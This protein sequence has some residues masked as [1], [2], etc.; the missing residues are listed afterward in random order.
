[1]ELGCAC[2]CTNTGTEGTSG[3]FIRSSTCSGLRTSYFYPAAITTFNKSVQYSRCT[4]WHFGWAGLLLVALSTGDKKQVPNSRK[5]SWKVGNFLLAHPP[6]F[7]HIHL[8][9]REQLL[10]FI[11]AAI[12]EHYLLANS[13]LF[14]C[15]I[16][17]P[18]VL[19]FSSFHFWG[20]MIL[21]F[22]GWS[23]PLAVPEPGVGQVNRA[24]PLA[25][26]S[27]PCCGSPS[28]VK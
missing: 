16:C 10:I 5:Q 19:S 23:N 14:M 18:W 28:P 12:T 25:Y 24:S 21:R 22:S 2:Q 13:R 27:H 1:M 11:L 7:I 8:L 4:I 15:P 20:K 6:L 3:T 9:S 26:R 17:L